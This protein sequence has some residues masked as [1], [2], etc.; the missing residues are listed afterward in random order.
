MENNSVKHA[1]IKGMKWGVRRYQN[2]DGSLTPAGRK[3]YYP[4]LQKQIKRMMPTSNKKHVPSQQE[5]I[6]M[7]SDE[8]LRKRASRIKAENDYMRAVNEYKN[9]TAKKKSAGRKFVDDVL[10]NSTKNIA[11]QYATQFGKSQIDK[12]MANLA[13]QAKN[14]S[15]KQ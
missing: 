8:E 11:T 15:S 5:R 3:R 4:S 2:K 13:E 9:L 14:R 12:I 6:R 10:L 7:M 1:G